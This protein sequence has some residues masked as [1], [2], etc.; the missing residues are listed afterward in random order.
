M[1]G[2][3]TENLEGRPSFTKHRRDAKRKFSFRYIYFPNVP[4]ALCRRSVTPR[5]NH[6]PPTRTPVTLLI[7]C[8]APCARGIFDNGVR[9]FKGV[10]RFI[11]RRDNYHLRWKIAVPSIRR[12]G[13]Q[14][15]RPRLR[16][17][18][19]FVFNFF[20]FFSLGFVYVYIYFSRSIPEENSNY[21]RGYR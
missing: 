19:K 1:A 20:L 7:L 11:S 14:C 17:I 16:A 9:N 2:D 8:V 4:F 12:F 15:N 13:L 5:A 18:I 6:S 10:V 21:R 3:S